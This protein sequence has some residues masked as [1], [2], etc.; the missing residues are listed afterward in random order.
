VQYLRKP[1]GHIKDDVVAAQDLVGAPPLLP[2]A[3]QA[4]I[5][6]GDRDARRANLG[7]LGNALARAVERQFLQ[8]TYLIGCGVH[9]A[10]IQ[11]RSFSL[12]LKASAARGGTVV[13]PPRSPPKV[14]QHRRRPDVDHRFPVLRHESITN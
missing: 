10:S 14:R 3:G 5:K 8:E 13:A 1:L 12:A 2:R 9:C 11:V 6:I 7:L 4:N